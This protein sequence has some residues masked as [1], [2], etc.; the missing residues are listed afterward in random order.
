MIA[1]KRHLMLYLWWV[2]DTENINNEY[3]KFL[4]QILSNNYN[5]Y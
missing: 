5:Y 1:V 4:A 3:Y 2:A